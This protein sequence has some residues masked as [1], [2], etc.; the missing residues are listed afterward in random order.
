MNGERL[1]DLAQVSMSDAEREFLFESDNPLAKRFVR[2]FCELAA[3]HLIRK[4]V[5]QEGCETMRADLIAG[6]ELVERRRR[7]AGT[8]ETH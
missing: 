4:P 7:M 5:P 1:A 6:L 3:Y 2:A 8:A